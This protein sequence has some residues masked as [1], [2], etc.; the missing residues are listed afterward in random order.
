MSVA[1][2][3]NEDVTTA[4][5][6]AE[7]IPRL[8][9]G[10]YVLAAYA[11]GQEGRTRR[12]GGRT[13]TQWFIVSDLGLTAI[14]GDDGV[15]GFVRSLATAQPGRQRQRAPDRAQQ[16][17]AGHG[18]DRRPRLRA[19]RRRAARGEGGQAP[20]VLVAE[21]AAGD[22]AFLDMAT[23]AFDL[24]DRGVKGRAEPGPVDAFAYADRG[25]YRPGESRAP[26]DAGAHPLR[27]GRRRSR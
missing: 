19:L 23:A 4:F 26:D 17:G 9:P 14:N 8:E 7:A 18:Q 21:T 10:V 15:H 24:T 22:Y 11:V 3:L 1:S 5:P 27:R 16:R 20:A 2:R 12:R 6:V 25:V 13:A